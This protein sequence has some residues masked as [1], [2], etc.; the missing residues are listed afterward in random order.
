MCN[1]LHTDCD[2]RDPREHL[3]APD[4]VVPR[5]LGSSEAHR[6]IP[7]CGSYERP[8]RQWSVALYLKTLGTTP[9]AAEFDGWITWG[10]EAPL[11]REL[12]ETLVRRLVE[13]WRGS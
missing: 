13:D 10:H 1:T 11:A 8:T 6:S 2:E 12:A 7:L 9:S 3:P 5:N 4:D